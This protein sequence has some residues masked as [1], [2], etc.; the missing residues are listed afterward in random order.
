MAIIG[1]QQ[2]STRA[3]TDVAA[4]RDRL[5]GEVKTLSVSVDVN[6]RQSECRS[7]IANYVSDVTE[8]ANALTR[9][10]LA[11]SVIARSPENQRAV[12][13]AITDY[14]N[15]LAVLSDVRRRSVEVCA[16]NVDYE[17]TG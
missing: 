7:K 3:I 4:E 5:R 1:T 10:G 9:Q 11:D 16:D 8:K 12:A 15:R 6:A 17:M 14:N 13:L 2:A